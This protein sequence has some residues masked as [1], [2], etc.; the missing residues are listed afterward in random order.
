MNRLVIYFIFFLI[1][2][3]ITF[4]TKFY[5][6]ELPPTFLI[7]PGGDHLGVGLA[8]YPLW[9]QTQDSFKNIVIGHLLIDLFFWFGI[10][11][12]AAKAWDLVTNSKK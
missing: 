11:V 7:I 9:Y 8:G 1:A 5:T 12:M 3:L 6:Y 2:A 4:L 10:V